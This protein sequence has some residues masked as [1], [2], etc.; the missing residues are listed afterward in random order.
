L[1][2]LGAQHGAAYVYD[3]ATVLQRAQELQKLPGIQRVLF[4]MKA[5]SNRELLKALEAQGVDF[6]CVAPGEIQRLLELF[7]KLDR[8]RILFTLNFAAR[9][10]YVWGFERGVRVTLDNLHPLKHYP[11]V[12]KGKDV[13]VRI[14]TGTGRGHHDK[15][16]TAGMHSKFGIPL[17]EIDEL[18]RLV[19]QAGARVVGLHA[20]TG[21]GVFNVENWR[22]VGTVLAGLVA[23]FPSVTAL[24]LGGGLGVPEKATDTGIDLVA[25]GKVLAELHAQY[26]K[27]GL[28][29]E[30]GRYLV[31]EA[32]VLLAQVTQ[33]KGKGA[34][35]YVGV[36]TGMNS[37]IRPALYGAHHDIVNLTRL[38]E[39][40]TDIVNIVGP[41]CESG[42]Q[43]GNDR[44]LPACYEG[45]VLLI[46]NAGAYGYVMSSNYNLRPA[47]VE[48]V[49]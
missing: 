32:G 23:R 45:D 1:L 37:L 17:F 19:K 8:S 39:P 16:R 48:V 4:A 49:I 35:Q 6:D 29:L 14:D 46:A 40:A 9:S 7:P 28:W 21:S 18:E 41:I 24:D 36:A 2:E 42:D 34:V 15:V 38:D 22:E 11:D 5:N 31:A 33:T 25:L 10:E 20:H 30:P 12:F 13:F 44:L 3:R 27:V 26:P 47:A 43:L